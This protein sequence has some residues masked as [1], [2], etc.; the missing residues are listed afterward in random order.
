MSKS[1]K[2]TKPSD[3]IS[4]D[5]EPLNATSSFP[6]ILLFGSTVNLML[7]MAR[8]FFMYSTEETDKSECR[9]ISPIEGSMTLFL[10]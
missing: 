8:P 9:F 10:K 3:D 1:I 6:E 7:F 5:E 4:T 2:A